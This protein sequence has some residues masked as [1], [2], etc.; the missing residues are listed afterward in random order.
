RHPPRRSPA[1]LDSLVPGRRDRGRGSG[2][3]PPAPRVVECGRGMTHAAMTHESS[4]LLTLEGISQLGFHSHDSGQTLANIPRLIQRRFRSDVCSV[5][6]LEPERGELLLGATVGLQPES[7]GRVRMRLDEGLTGLVAER[8][9]PVMVEDAF[10]HPRFK[11]FAEAGEDPYH[12]FLGVPLIAGGE[13]QGALVVQ[14]GEA[15]VFSS[16]E[17]RMLVTVGSQL[18]PLVSDA[19]LLERVVAMAHEADQP[20]PCAEAAGPVCW[21]GTPLS[22]GLGLGRAYIINGFSDWLSNAPQRS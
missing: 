19:R 10:T 5:Y 20:A 14:A 4:L 12:S 3:R 17:V 18:A 2:W 22:P 1:G 11:Y 6:L 16:N 13:L 21:R 8:L 15:H 7:V 9:A